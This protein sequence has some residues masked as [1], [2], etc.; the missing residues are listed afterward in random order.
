MGFWNYVHT[1]NWEP[2]KHEVMRAGRPVSEEEL[3]ALAPKPPPGG[4]GPDLA[5]AVQAAKN[6]IWDK[7]PIPSTGGLKWVALAVLG[8]LA[9]ILLARK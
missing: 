4:Y 9:V 7:L 3:A 1:G 2:A 5:T 8:V 6:K